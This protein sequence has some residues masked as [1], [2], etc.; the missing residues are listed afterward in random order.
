[1][2]AIGDSVMIDITPDLKKLFPGIVIDAQVG[3]QMIQAPTVIQQLK[4]AGELGH[5]VVIIALG[6]N[7]PF[8]ENQLLSLLH[9]LG[10]VQQIVLVNTREPRPWQNVVNSTLAQVAAIYP[11]T[12]LV[13][14]YAASAGKNG[15]FYP[16]GV[17]LNPQGAQYYANL[18]AGAIDSKLGSQTSQTGTSAP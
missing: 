3:R 18:V 1:M 7:G 17:H 11:H 13:N 4:S 6:T 2:T 8:T 9:S 14:W 5:R 12:T 16:D 15:L 10:P